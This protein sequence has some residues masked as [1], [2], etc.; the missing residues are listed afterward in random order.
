M[1]HIFISYSR[2]DLKLA[3][4]IVDALSACKLDTW[5]DWKSIPKGEDWEQE[6]YRGIEEADAFLFLISP[7]SVKSEMCNREIAHAVKNG[8]RILPVFIADAENKRIYDVTDQ[9]LYNEQKEEIHRRNFIICRQGSDEFDTT[10]EEIQTT[11]HTDYEWVRY[12]TELLVKALNWERH[13]DDSRLL[14]GKELRESY[15]QLALASKDTDP[16]PTDLQR[17]YLSASQKHENSLISRTRLFGLV[18]LVTLILVGI[19]GIVLLDRIPARVNVEG[20]IFEIRNRSGYRFLSQ[21]VGSTISIYAEP[22]KLAPDGE[23]LF[24]VGTGTDGAHPGTVLAY[25]MRGNIKWQYSVEDD[26]YQGPPGN[27]KIIRI[28]VDEILGNDRSQIIFTAQKSDWFPTELVVLDAEG[29]LFASYWNSGFIYDVLRQDLD[30]DGIKEL[31]ISAVNNNLGWLVD[32]RSKHPVIVYVLSPKEDFTGQT[33]PVLIPDW[34]FGTEYHNWIAVFEPFTV[35]G[36]HL[37]TANVDGENL[38]EVVFNPQG[39]YIWLDEFGRIQNVGLSDYWQ[40]LPEGEKSPADFICY[41]T[42]EGDGWHIY[43]RIDSDVSCP[44]YVGE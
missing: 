4:K 24:V 40:T 18:F 32:E 23:Y 12:H 25:D 10:I 11:I 16:W 29:K 15:K 26:P 6:I 31:V 8:K 27:F 28:I 44:W 3:Q 9:F 36:I 17:Q 37:R 35:T 20:Q 13:K 21:D 1:S 22:Q 33:F 14:R 39:G 5:I 42:L 34:P 43:G 41:L 38:I 7:D 30:A 2:S 19:A